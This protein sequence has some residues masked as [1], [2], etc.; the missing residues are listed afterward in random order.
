MCKFHIKDIPSLVCC[1]CG[2]IQCILCEHYNKCS[3][4]LSFSCEDCTIKLVCGHK[5]CSLQCVI[6]NKEKMC[7]DYC[8]FLRDVDATG[9]D[10]E[11]L[12]KLIEYWVSQVGYECFLFWISPENIKKD[13]DNITNI[14]MSL[15]IIF[16]IFTKIEF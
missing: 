10:V 12:T 6:S 7:E 8:F 9:T 2:E 5:Y 1:Q 14:T 4:C 3:F 16:E 11:G 15:N 13:K